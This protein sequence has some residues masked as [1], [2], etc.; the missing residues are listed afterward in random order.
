MAY[1]KGL[2]TFAISIG[3]LKNLKPF[4]GVI[5]SPALN[6]LVS[7][8]VGQ[9]AF[10]NGKPIKVSSISKLSQA[11]VGFDVGFAGKRVAAINNHILPLTDQVAYMP[12]LG[13]VATGMSYLSQGV[14]DAYLHKAYIWDFA[15]GCAIV[16][17]AGGK[18][19]NFQGKPVDWS[20]EEVEVLASNGPIHQQIVDK[21]NK[22]S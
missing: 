20:G 3:L 7:A 15:A 10:L 1:S 12:S 4:L 21:L 18:V 8:Q 6:L 5:Y 9:G 22:K 16:S 19:T 17:E 11:I 2:P 14:Y 13:S